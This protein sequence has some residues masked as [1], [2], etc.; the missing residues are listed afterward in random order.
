MAVPPA[1]LALITPV[2]AVTVT[3]EV[4]DLMAIPLAPFASMLPLLLLTLTWLM[5]SI[6]PLPA[7]LAWMV[8]ACPL[9]LTTVA[10]MP[11]RAATTSRVAVVGFT[12]AAPAL[13]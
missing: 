1:A 11:H 4:S 7:A 10:R 2:L 12:V 3:S 13:A 6:A 9:T 8:P 5:A